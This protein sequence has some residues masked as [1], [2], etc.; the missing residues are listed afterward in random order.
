MGIMKKLAILSLST[1]LA[2]CGGGGGGS[3]PAATPAA[4][5]NVTITTVA[6]P[7]ATTSTPVDASV[8]GT[9]PTLAY[10]SNGTTSQQ[11]AVITGAGATSVM[12]FS[13][14]SF[15]LTG[16]S[17]SNPT[18]SSNGG[19]VR[20]GGNVLAYCSAGMRTTATGGAVDKPFQE[21]TRVF[22]TANLVAVS[23]LA[24]LY[25]F[26]FAQFDCAGNSVNMTSNSDGTFTR[27][28][29]TATTPL[30]ATTVT[31]LFSTTGFTF[32]GGS[33]FKYRAYKYTAA[34]A[35]RYFLTTIVAQ[36]NPTANFVTL[37]Y[38]TP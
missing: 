26:T 7:T 4:S 30:N 38:Q 19:M 12:T 1:I 21:G 31:Q 17:G 25:G 36:V 8:A 13:S 16:A 15:T 28:D 22:L 23:N 9:L 18:W 5:N 34:G 14:P 10:A 3:T 29:S 11:D 33:N 24:E 27:V 6:T 20:A 35:T 32:G 2:A 37:S